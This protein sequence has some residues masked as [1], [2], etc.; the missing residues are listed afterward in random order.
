MVLVKIGRKECFSV[1]T[2]YVD[3]GTCP[4]CINHVK[5]L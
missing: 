1:T 4:A 5:T 3:T 2:K